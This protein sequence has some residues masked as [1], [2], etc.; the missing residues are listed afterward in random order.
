MPLAIF[1]L[2]QL[3]AA[4]LV[5]FL[6]YAAL[7]AMFYFV[8]LYMQQVLGDDALTAGLKFLPMTGSVFLGSRVA[9]G[10]PLGREALMRGKLGRVEVRGAELV[11]AA[12]AHDALFSFDARA[13]IA[14]IEHGY[15]L[16]PEGEILF[17]KL[18]PRAILDIESSI[19]S[20]W[21]VVERAQ[22]DPAR[23][24]LELVHPER[25]PDIDLLAALVAA[26]REHGALIALDDLSGGAGSLAC[27]EATKPQFA[28]LD[29]AITTGIEDS[30]PRRHLISAVVE[31]AH[32]AGVKVVAEGVERVGEFE[33]M[34]DLGVDYGQGFYFGQPTEKPL[35]V[36][37][38][39]LQRE[40][41]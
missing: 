28:K 6:L 5:V 25:C 36:D 21:P 29:H 23:V 30:A 1:R 2:A 32:E 7:F 41:V 15:P 19:R 8:T 9:K 10:T 35:P 38:R 12:E 17:V 27:L 13:R 11:A 22:G 31:I 34:R 40:L 39:L 18:D 20:T 14:A 37:P 4:N 16:L 3:R 26:H 24:C 33:A